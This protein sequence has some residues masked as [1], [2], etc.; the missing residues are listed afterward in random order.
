M[1]SLRRLWLQCHR[2][3]ALTLGGILVLSGLTGALLV[4]APPIDRWLHADYFVAASSEDKTPV[5][6]ELLRQ[7][8]ASEFGPDAALT[9]RPPRQAGDTL[10]VTVRGSWVGTVYLHPSSGV[11]QGR[12]GANASVVALLHG[13]HSNLWLQ[14]T[15]KAVLAWVALAYLVLLV[16]GLVLWWPRKWPPSFRM[17]LDKGSL[18]ALFDIHRTGGVLLALFLAVSVATG[19]Y[20]VWRPI[21]GWISWVS[22]AAPVTAPALPPGSGKAL[23]LDDL[24]ARAQAVFPDGRI[25]FV[26]YKPNLDKPLAIRMDLPDDPHPNGRSNV[27]LDPRSGAVLA[28]HR[29]S[30]QDPG[31]KINSYVFPLHTGELGGVP[32]QVVVTLLGVALV[33][34]GGS[35]I[36]LWWTRR[37]VRRRAFVVK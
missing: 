23:P 15:G 24:V 1:T 10:Q 20:L 11:E 17:V 32:L 13:F 26:L 8:L 6:L 37:A 7:R 25:G 12:R 4:V 18:R 21:G 30:E 29:W 34:L 33:I 35:G 27:W 16:S 36:G 5:S 2:W 28:A 31:T 22:G 9:F 19:A 14:Q 3:V